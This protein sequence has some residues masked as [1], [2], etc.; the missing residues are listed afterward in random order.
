MSILYYMA[1]PGIGGGSPAMRDAGA[2]LSPYRRYLTT[3]IASASER[4]LSICWRSPTAQEKKELDQCLDA[5][6]ARSE[7]AGLKK[8]QRRRG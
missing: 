3:A 5:R 4:A 6:Y 7:S 2:Q 1:L 8:S